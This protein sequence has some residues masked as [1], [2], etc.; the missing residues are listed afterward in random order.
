MSR[1]IA[2]SLVG[3]AIGVGLLSMSSASAA[4]VNG[5]VIGKAASADALTQKVVWRGR[6]VGWR[7]YGWRR[8]VG[9]GVV[10]AGVATA[11]AYGA[12]NNG[13]GNY[14]YDNYA[15]DTS[16]YGDNY[17]YGS[18][19]G[20]NSGY[21]WR[22]GW[23]VASAAQNYNYGSP[24]YNY[25]YAS[26]YNSGNYNSGNWDGRR[27]Y[28]RRGVAAATYAATPGYG[29]GNNAGYASNY[30]PDNYY[31]RG[32]YRPGVAAATYAATPGYGYGNN[33]GYASNYSGG[34][35]YSQTTYSQPS[36]SATTYT[37][38]T[39]AAGHW[40][41][42]YCINAVRERFGISSTDAGK[43]TNAWA[44]R[45]CMEGGPMRIG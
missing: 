18:G 35:S 38:P 34:N 11:A 2:I 14:G 5:A 33:A 10:G 42:A 45:R 32:T 20:I 19:I 7:G 30:N 31:G 22:P 37:S 13:Y 28:V 9:V 24:N 3:A 6:G 21:R 8:G 16:G 29:Y 15:S 36:A 4:P 40:T 41:M 26:N 1:R 39:L 17:N 12:Y 43:S 25:G 23:R 27:T 44:V